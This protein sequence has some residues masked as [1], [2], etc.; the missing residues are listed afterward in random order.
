M[1]IIH[2]A[3]AYEDIV[4]FLTVVSNIDISRKVASQDG[5]AC[6][7]LIEKDVAADGGKA[8]GPSFGGRC[9]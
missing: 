9:Q 6:A 2:V 5:T 1:N 7:A 4:Y 8:V 3:I